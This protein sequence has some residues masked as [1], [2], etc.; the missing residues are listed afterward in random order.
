[1]VTDGVAKLLDVGM[2]RAFPNLYSVIF[3]APIDDTGV[4]SLRDRTLN[5]SYYAEKISFGGDQVIETEYSEATKQFFIK[6]A[7]R[8][9]TATI[10]F[11]ETSQYKVLNLLRDWM[12]NIYDFENNVFRDWKPWG[13]VE[14]AIDAMTSNMISGFINMANAYPTSVTYPSYDWADGNP[15]KVNGTFSFSDFS[16]GFPL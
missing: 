7:Q 14:V 6:N 5:L 9:K 15:I 2:D 11:R 4:H 10:T 16:T 3:T 13:R 1:M 8:I 12:D